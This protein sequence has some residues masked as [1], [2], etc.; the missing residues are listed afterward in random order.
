MVYFPLNFLDFVYVL[1]LKSSCLLAEILQFTSIVCYHENK[2]FFG[3]D[4][5]TSN[6]QTILLNFKADQKR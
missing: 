6:P 3:E 2:Y 4:N 1:T 5:F